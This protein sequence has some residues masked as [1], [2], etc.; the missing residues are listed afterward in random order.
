M[1][2][3]ICSRFLLF[4]K[5][6]LIELDH[7]H[8]YVAGFHEQG[9]RAIL[10]GHIFDIF[11]LIVFFQFVQAL[12]GLHTLGQAALVFQLQ[13]LLF[14]FL[15][16]LFAY[17]FVQRHEFDLSALFDQVIGLDQVRKFRVLANAFFMQCLDAWDNAGK[18]RIG[19]I[20]RGPD[21]VPG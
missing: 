11:V 10:G 12:D 16:F 5:L 8:Q 6:R 3:F 18:I 21:P 2:A 15:L 17:F 7:I 1:F 13:L 9:Y 4:G 20:T 19:L 14:Q